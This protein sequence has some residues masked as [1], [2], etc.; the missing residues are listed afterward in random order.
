[1]KSALIGYTGFVGHNLSKQ[2]RFDDLYNRKNI[3]D[4]KEEEYDLV[5]CAAPSAE[6]WKANL[7]PQCD[8]EKINRLICDIICLK[9]KLFVYISTVDVY[10]DPMNVDE[11]TAIS[12]AD[13]HA[14]G[15][16]RLLLERFTRVHFKDC[17]IVRL[18]ALFGDGLKKNFIFDLIHNNR[19]D[20]TDMDS[21]FQFY[22]LDHLWS[23][24]SIALGN[25]IRLLNVTSEPLSAREVAA[26]CFGVD[27][28]NKTGVPPVKYDVRSLYAHVYNGKNGYLYGRDVILAELKDF[29]DRYG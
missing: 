7:D 8:A 20:L 17:L 16:H 22:C 10:R 4:A 5:V 11:A 29:A 25:S 9:T 18:P 1:M 24:I 13:L 19:P 12:M 26:R 6:K 14:Y 27:I 15:K 23:D 3:D 28:L 21:E 2:V